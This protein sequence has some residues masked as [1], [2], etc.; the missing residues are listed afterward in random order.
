MTYRDFRRVAEGLGFKTSI[1]TYD[2]E[3][4]SGVRSYAS[5][6]TREA[7]VGW[8]NTNN[9][10]D[11][12]K[13]GS[14]FRFTALLTCTPLSDRYDNV[15][16]K[17]KNGS[18]VKSVTALT[19]GKSPELRV[20]MTN[21]RAEASDGISSLEREWLNNFFGNKISYIEEY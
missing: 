13:A 11:R 3:V 6:S 1:G 10:T 20:E 7:G 8:I 17:H 5:V 19:L 16:A 21:D 18:Y 9:I 12:E 2:L 14:L 4:Y 15:I